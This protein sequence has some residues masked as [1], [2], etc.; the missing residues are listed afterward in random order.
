MERE[1]TPH[2]FAAARHRM[3][4]LQLRS[5]GIRDPR[6]LDAMARVPRH[7]FVSA[8]QSEEAYEDRPLSIAEGQTVSQPYIVAVTLGSLEIQPGD[9][10]LEIGTGSGYQTALIA[11]LAAQVFSIERYQVLADQARCRL[12]DLGYTNVTVIVGDGSQGFP[13]NAPYDVIVAAAAAPQIP[14]PLL[15]QLAETGRMVIPVGPSSGQELQLIRKHGTEFRITTLDGCRF[16]PM[17]GK[18]AYAQGW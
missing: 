7:R 17:I 16:V 15:D 11:E 9:R 5:R 13:Q 2:A 6:V 12:S 14:Q 8:E 4:E 10:V 1:L 18:D 3:V